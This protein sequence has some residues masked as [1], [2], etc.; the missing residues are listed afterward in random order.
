MN[1]STSLLVIV[2][3]L[4]ANGFFVAAEFALVKAR[5]FRIEA[6]ANDGSKAAELTL[7]I[8]ANL[9]SYLAA[10]QLGITMASLGLGWVGEPAVAHLLEPLFLRF[11][12]SEAVMHTT[13]FVTGFLIFSSLHIVVGEQV[14]KTFAIRQPEP[15]SVWCAYPLHWTYLAVLPLNW[16]L[17]RATSAL[18][19][20][21]GVEP[22]G[23]GDV[24][25][26]DEL[27]GLVAVSS[28]SGELETGHADM[29]RNL[30]EFDQRHVGRVMI[31]RN[32]LHCLDAAASPEKNLAVIRETEHSRF[33]VIDM[34]DDEAIVGIL[35]VKDI[36]RAMMAGEVEPWTDLKR[37]CREPLVVP[38]SQRVARLFELMRT[39]REHMSLIVDEYGTFVGAVSLEDLLE[40][41]VGEIEDETDV[42]EPSML[43]E[44]LGDDRWEMDGL[45]SLGDVEKVVGLVVPVDLDANT[46]SGLFME[47]LA[48][49]PV[50]DDEIEEGDFRLRVLGIVDRRVGRTAIDR[51]APM[52]D[53]DVNA[54]PTAEEPLE[55]G[56]R[57]SGSGAG[58]ARGPS[59]RSD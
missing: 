1:T 7:R 37:F 18:L 6:L 59:A 51:I 54:M 5:G 2:F 8:Q 16:L 32:S 48:R 17:S 52:T 14:P 20:L 41:I 28:E 9:E 43:I 3:L 22:A 19:S 27:K 46:L 29:L 12:L 49:M 36:H 4:V 57:V 23:H 40:E 58:D 11:G 45:V 13:S 10:C 35:L 30:F 21:F 25:S 53:V 24:L 47:R 55:A 34:A 38:E 44:K 15:V 26:G 33:P 50:I 56:T 42:D 39:R 31:P